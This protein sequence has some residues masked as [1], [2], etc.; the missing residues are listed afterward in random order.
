LLD[1]PPLSFP[2]RRSSDLTFAGHHTDGDLLIV[3]D[4]SQGGAVS[5]INIFKWQNGSL[6]L[7]ATES[8]APCDPVNDN[9]TFCGLVNN[10]FT[11]RDRKSTRLN[12]SHGS[13]S[14]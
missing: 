9:N 6:V 10:A 12:S 13:I 5:T 2:T 14:Y 4:F 3:S 1:L 7:S 11:Q 8:P